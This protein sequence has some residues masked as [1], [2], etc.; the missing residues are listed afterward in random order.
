MSHSQFHSINLFILRHAWLNLWDKHMTTGR[1]NQVTTY[2]NAQ[3]TSCNAMYSC[4]KSAF[5]T[6]GVHY[7][8]LELPFDFGYCSESR[9]L[10]QSLS[11]IVLLDAKTTAQLFRYLDLTSFR[12]GSSC[13]EKNKNHRL[14][15]G[16]P[17]TGDTSKAHSVA[18]YPRV[19]I[20][21][22]HS[23]RQVIHIL[24]HRRL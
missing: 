5:S 20:C 23:H 3:E 14:Q 16:L 22:R 10:F 4:S 6:A 17:A 2:P 15:R 8:A 21:F 11:R 18:A 24:L 19:I 13:F 7:K 1:I 9:I 12:Q